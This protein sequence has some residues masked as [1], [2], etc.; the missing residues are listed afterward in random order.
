MRV[1]VAPDKFEGSLR[2][3][4]AAE[5]IEAGLRRARP[6]AEVVRLPLGDGGAGTLDALLA[7]GVERGPVRGT[8]CRG[9]ARVPAPAA[10][11]G[12]GGGGGRGA[13]GHP[14]G[15][16]AGGPGGSRLAPRRAF[17]EM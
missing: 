7:A 2:A 8:G 9:G 15:R 11:G 13:Q 4:Q 1:V 17:V 6:D 10:A 5:A 12:G 3:G 16:A 14:P